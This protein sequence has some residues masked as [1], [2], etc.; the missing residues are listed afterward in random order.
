MHTQNEIYP[1]LLRTY[2]HSVPRKVS[3]VSRHCCSSRQPLL[4]CTA[5]HTVGVQYADRTSSKNERAFD[6]KNAGW[7]GYLTNIFNSGRR[8]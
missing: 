4:L 6:R 7:R 3:V 8:S 5:I 1:R 2:V